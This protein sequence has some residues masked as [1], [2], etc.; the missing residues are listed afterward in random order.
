MRKVMIT[1]PEDF[2]A[3]VDEVAEREHRNRSELI[4]E[5][6]RQYIAGSREKTASR[7]E[8]IRRALRI[9]EAARSKT[10]NPSFDSTQFIREWRET[11]REHEL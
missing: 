11:H 1:V 5:A 4:R 10:R 7:R 8:A 9:Q 6:V 2:L 3:E